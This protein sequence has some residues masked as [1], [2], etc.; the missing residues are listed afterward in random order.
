MHNE[1]SEGEISCVGHKKREIELQETVINHPRQA[2]ENQ[3]S[4]TQRPHLA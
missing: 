1:W 3:P 2:I 4:K